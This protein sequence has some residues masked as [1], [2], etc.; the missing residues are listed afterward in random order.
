MNFGYCRALTFRPGV[1][2]G[3]DLSWSVSAFLPCYRRFV[4]YV[5]RLCCR[6]FVI[7]LPSIPDG[8]QGIKGSP[9]IVA[10]QSLFSP[11]IRL[12]SRRKS[13]FSICHTSRRSPFA[14][15]RAIRHLPLTIRFFFRCNSSR[16]ASPWQPRQIP[17][18]LLGSQPDS[19]LAIVV[20]N[21]TSSVRSFSGGSQSNGGSW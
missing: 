17:P 9:S 16:N 6:T 11:T 13:S 3:L 20:H 5:M 10:G 15:P 21:T 14:T 1:Q 4:L 7:W 8:E 18:S 19:Q 2:V 12:F